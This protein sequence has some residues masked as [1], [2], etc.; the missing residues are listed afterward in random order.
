M[1][2]ISVIVI[3]ETLDFF[4]LK[5]EV[6]FENIYFAFVYLNDPFGQNVGLFL[7]SWIRD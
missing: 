6:E 4:V 5:T 1:Y 7:S 3:Q 2:G